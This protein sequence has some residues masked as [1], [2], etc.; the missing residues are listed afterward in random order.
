MYQ[1]FENFSFPKRFIFLS[2]IAVTEYLGLVSNPLSYS[3]QWE[4][5][6]TCGAVGLLISVR[7][8]GGLMLKLFPYPKNIPANF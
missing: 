5:S 8:N 2:Y 6:K 3:F 4:R 1:E 7:S